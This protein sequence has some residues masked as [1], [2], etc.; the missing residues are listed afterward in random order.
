MFGATVNDVVLTVVAGALRS[1]L[2]NRNIPPY[3][4]RAMVP[5]NVY[6]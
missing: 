2:D 4:L 3:D 5:A 6:R 1:W